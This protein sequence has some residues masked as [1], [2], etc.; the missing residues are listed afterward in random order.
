[1]IR[2]WSKLSQERWLRRRGEGARERGGEGDT[3]HFV[4][5]YFSLI[6]A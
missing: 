5:K 3:V 6:S 1:M 4:D 2:R